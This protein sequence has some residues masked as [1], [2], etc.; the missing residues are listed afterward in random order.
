QFACDA[1]VH[2]L[3]EWHA[4]SIAQFKKGNLARR[5]LR[6]QG[7]ARD[8]FAAFDVGD[9]G[10][11]NAH[12]WLLVGVVQLPQPRDEFGDGGVRHFRLQTVKDRSERGTFPSA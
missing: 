3:A 2:W 4:G 6:S 8:Q 9:P 1:W 7:L 10:A 5:F 12:E 11:R